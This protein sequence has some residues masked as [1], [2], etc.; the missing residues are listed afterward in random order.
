M[1]CETRVPRSWSWL[2]GW[3]SLI[4]MASKG[5]EKSMLVDGCSLH[6]LEGGKVKS[7]KADNLHL[8]HTKQTLEKYPWTSGTRKKLEHSFYPT[9][10]NGVARYQST[11]SSSQKRCWT[12]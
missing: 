2:F 8:K 11:V 5:N 1:E 9:K 6:I 7:V 4:V 12:R 3:I 10:N